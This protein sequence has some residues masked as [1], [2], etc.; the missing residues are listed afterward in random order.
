MFDGGTIQEGKVTIA[1]YSK[2]KIHVPLTIMTLPPEHINVKRR[3]EEEPV[4]T[5]CM[6]FPYLSPSISGGV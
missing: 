5:L 4:E 6:Q 1:L 3:R 2:S